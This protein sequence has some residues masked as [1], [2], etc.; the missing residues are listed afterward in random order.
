[1]N[2][3]TVPDEVIDL[4]IYSCRLFRQF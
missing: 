1:L 4:M 2:E 3:I